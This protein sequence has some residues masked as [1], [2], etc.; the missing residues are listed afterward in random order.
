MHFPINT[1]FKIVSQ[2]DA[3]GQVQV[4]QKQGEKIVFTNGC[5]D[6]VHLGHIDYLERARNLGT[7]LVVGLNSDASVTRLKGKSRPVV[8]EYPRLRMMSAFAFIDLVFLF[9]ED[10]PL[11]IIEKLKPDILVKGNDYLI[12][13]IVGAEFVTKNGGR[14]ATIELVKGYSTSALIEKIKKLNPSDEKP[15]IQKPKK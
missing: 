6:I 7:R 5:F 4:W 8:E 15:D 12:E 3:V 13:N 14:V 2:E 1:S 11:Q 10:T 9:E